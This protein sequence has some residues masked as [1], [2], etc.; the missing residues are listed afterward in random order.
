MLLCLATQNISYG[1]AT[2]TKLKIQN[3]ITC[4]PHQGTMPCHRA[5]TS[6]IKLT[7]KLDSFTAQ[8]ESCLYGTLQGNTVANTTASELKKSR[9]LS[10]FSR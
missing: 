10:A 6:C 4:L 8:V 9:M 7:L 1:D 2:R 5:L 3:G